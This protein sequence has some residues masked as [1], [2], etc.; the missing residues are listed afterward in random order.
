MAV[1]MLSYTQLGQRL[2]CSPEAARAL[3]KRLRLPRQKANDGKVLVS[4]DLT[5]ISHRPMS[6]RSPAG[7]HPVTAALKERVEELEAALAKVEAA[8]AGHRA[9]FEYE[10][11]RAQQLMSELL[12]TIE[13][14]M[15]AREETARVEGELAMLRQETSDVRT[16][17]D[18]WR[19]QVER[20]TPNERERRSW[21]KRLAG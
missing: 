14:A 18:G 21:W 15:S 7:H 9:D 20:L 6:A 17:R 5:E 10:R 19:M 1:E 8:A 13:E 3:V 4:I 12:R 11:Q 2:S 16:D